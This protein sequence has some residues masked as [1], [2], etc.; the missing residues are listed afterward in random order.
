MKQTHKKDL[1]KKFVEEPKN[2]KRIFWAREMKILN[3]LLEMFPN[4]D[5]WGKVSLPKS[6][7]LALLRSPA[8]L[9][10]VRKKYREFNYKIPKKKNIK[11][12]KKFGE[13]K[14]ISKKTKTIRG[15]I[16]GKN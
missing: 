2:Q 6:N 10:R 12:G 14:L 9:K 5:F 13:D 3:D 1:I 15:F 11:I 4:L 8:G 16:D 7:S